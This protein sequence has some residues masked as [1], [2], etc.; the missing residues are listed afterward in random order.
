MTG[1]ARSNNEFVYENKKYSWVWEIKS[2]NAK[3]LDIKIRLPNWLEEIS[4]DIKKICSKVFARGTF[5]VCLEIESENATTDIKINEDLLNSLI[6]TTRQIYEKNQDLFNK[7]TPAEFLKINGI[8]SLAENTVNEEELKIIKNTL[9]ESM[10]DVA[11]ILKQDRL[12]EGEKIAKVL[13]EILEKIKD[14]VA[15]VEKITLNTPEKLKE[16]IFNQVKEL[17]PDVSVSSERLEQEIVLL[18]MRA[19]V[20]EEIDR[21]YAHIK[22]AFELLN[23]DAPVGRRLDFLCQELNRE[24]NTLCSKSSDIEQTKYGMELKA[25]IEQFREQVQNME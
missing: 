20:K 8:L 21:L 13:L 24:A 10:E 12:K 25:L 6:Q 9:L 17:M 7:P 19:D 22:T 3:G 23:D 18:V 11:L 2:V 4:E 14:T 15:K 5:S 16:K 1:F